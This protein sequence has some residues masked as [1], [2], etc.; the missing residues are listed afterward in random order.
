MTAYYSKNTGF[1]LRQDVKMEMEMGEF[2]VEVLHK[3][4]KKVGDVI[5]VHRVIQK[6][7]GQS[8]TMTL[9]DIK[10]NV[11]IPKTTFEPPPE[12]QALLNK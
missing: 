3:D 10:V 2:A 8:T 12:V 1:L 5:M 9:T 4:Y 11:D 6:T 7:P